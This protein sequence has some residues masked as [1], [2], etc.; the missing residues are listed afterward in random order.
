MCGV[1]GF[2]LK[3]PISLIETFK[4]LE[5]L[6]IHQYS[7]EAKPVGGY[8]AGIAVLLDDGSVV[9]E[10]IGKT[11]GS[12]AKHLAEISKPKVNSASVCVAHVRMPS[13]EFIQTSMFKE[14]SQP[15]VVEFDPSLTIVSVHN[16]KVENYR[17]LR[18]ELGEEHVFESEKHE[19]I[20]SE[21]IPHYFEELLNE[22]GDTDKAMYKLFDALQGSNAVGMLQVSEEDAFLHLVHKGKTRGLTVWT[23][24]QNEFVFCS[25]KEPLMEQFNSILAKG[26]FNE[27]ISIAWHE[28][29]GLKLSF[30]III[31]R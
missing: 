16:G 9:H 29:V 18:A 2:A 12:P 8:G 5:K 24:E 17:Q 26:K 14:T 23:N 31:G 6:E 1:F 30:P 11:A 15:Y 4:L 25:R 21:V 22:M 10:K 13:P 20:D 19:L 28:N 7:Q 27:K 3:K